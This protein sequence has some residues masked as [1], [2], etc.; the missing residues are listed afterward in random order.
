M[1]ADKGGWVR[2]LVKVV[3]LEKLHKVGS[4]RMQVIF[5]S[6]YFARKLSTAILRST[7]IGTPWMSLSLSIW[8]ARVSLCGSQA[9]PSVLPS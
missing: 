1:S 6:F 3:S 8:Q 5:R 9:R 2:C 4:C 7:C